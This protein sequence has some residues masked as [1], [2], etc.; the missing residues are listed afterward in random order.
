M[1]VVKKTPTGAREVAPGLNLRNTSVAY[2]ANRFLQKMRLYST[3]FA[4]IL[5]VG[6]VVLALHFSVENL[7]F[8]VFFTLLILITATAMT[9]FA[10]EGL[11]QRRRTGKSNKTP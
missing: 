6:L 1:Y 10:V 4:T 11:R 5:T 9:V 8:K 7:E 3:V 2:R